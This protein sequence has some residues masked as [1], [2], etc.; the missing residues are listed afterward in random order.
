MGKLLL[1]FIL[2]PLIDAWLLFQLGGMLGFA[3]TIALVVA[4]GMIGAWLFKL[5]GSRTWAKWQDSLAQGQVPEEGVLG[6][7]MLLL[8]GALLV[9]PGV[10]TD[11]VGLL[12]LLPPSRRVIAKLLKPR[13]S[14]FVKQKARAVVESPNVRV[15]S[16]NVSGGMGGVHPGP[17]ASRDEP[18]RADAPRVDVIGRRI[19]ISAGSGRPGRPRV[20]DAD[21]EIKPD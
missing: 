12:L 20:I 3:S 13:L 14:E 8:G 15:V 6:G 5:E 1:L 2:V 17:R 7:I 11:A 19:P 9:T 10:I 18:G 4:T 16:F 21:F